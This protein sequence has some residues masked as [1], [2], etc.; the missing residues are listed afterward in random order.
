MKRRKSMPLII[1]MGRIFEESA[2][3]LVLDQSCL[4]TDRTLY[5]KLFDILRRCIYR[6]FASGIIHNDAS[7]P[8]LQE[9][10]FGEKKRIGMQMEEKKC[11]RYMVYK[12]HDKQFGA[13]HLLTIS[14]V[15]AIMRFVSAEGGL[16]YAEYGYI[17]RCIVFSI[18]QF[19]EKLDIHSVK[20]PV[21]GLDTPF[22]SI[23]IKVLLTIEAVKAYLRLYGDP[24]HV[25]IVLSNNGLPE[26]LH[27]RCYNETDRLIKALEQIYPDK[28]YDPTASLK[29]TVKQL[30]NHGFDISEDYQS[31]LGLMSE[32]QI[33]E[34][35]FQQEKQAEI[36][37]TH[38]TEEEYGRQFQLSMQE[39]YGFSDYKL[40]NITKKSKYTFVKFRKGIT[41]KYSKTTLLCIA[42]AMELPL[43]DFCRYIW[44]A[45]EAFPCDDRDRMISSNIGFGMYDIDTIDEEIAYELGESQ[46]L[47]K[48]DQETNTSQ[49]NH[50]KS[51]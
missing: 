48:P 42:L 7:D 38:I 27:I 18:L 19:L 12:L 40:A 36:K 2:D 8:I 37:R 41:Q 22:F 44:A 9:F 28:S 32:I 34:K 30:C 26:D 45:G 50:K 13:D 23:E 51:N 47:T 49:K 16:T 6:P 5:R 11:R 31:E 39:Q 15:R 1:K 20:M 17:I 25:T 35:R 21:F 33:L 14:S 43:E 29:N 4:P 46:R 24:L 10:L 3:V